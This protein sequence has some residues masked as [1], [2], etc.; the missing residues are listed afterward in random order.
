MTF[1]EIME[2][3]GKLEYH[4]KLLVS[5][6]EGTERKFDYLIV[7]KSLSEKEVDDI[8]KYCENLSNEIKKQKAEGFVYFHP[9]Y[10]EFESFLSPKLKPEEVIE[11]CL[12]QK[13]F[14]PLMEELK[15]YS[16]L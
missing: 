3:I 12:E 16:K 15:K 6:V 11:T 7:K 1:D 13:L 14:V 8:L 2:K 5:M 4:Q 9:L 10:N